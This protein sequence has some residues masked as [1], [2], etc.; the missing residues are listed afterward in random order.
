MLSEGAFHG[1]CEERTKQTNQRKRNMRAR[2]AIVLCLPP[3]GRRSIQRN[4]LLRRRTAIGSKPKRPRALRRP[5]FRDHNHPNM[6]PLR[7]VRSVS[8]RLAVLALM[9][10]PL[11]LTGCNLKSG[12]FIVTKPVHIR[13]F[14]AL[15]DGGQVT[16][17]VGDTTIAAGLP[18]EGLTSYQDTD[19]GN[20]E[21]KVTVGSGSTIVDQ[22]TLLLDDSKYTYLVYG[23]SAAPTAQLL[24]DSTQTPNGGEFALVVPNGAFGSGGLDFYVTTPGAPLDNMS[25]NLGNIPYSSTTSF[26]TFAAGAYQVRA[27]LPNSKQV[28]Y[29][30]GTVTFSERTVYYFFFYTRGS[31]TLVNAALLAEDTAGSGTLLNSKLAQFKVVHA[32]PGTDPINAQYDGNPAFAG[33]P[34]PNASSYA[35]LPAGTH[36]ITVETTTAPGALIASLQRSFDAAT[37]A[38]V[39]VTGLPGAQTAFALS[40][41]NLPGTAGTARIRFVNAAPNL[42]PVDVLVNFARKVASLS[43]NAGSSYI[44]FPEDTYTIDFTVAG[45]ATSLLTLQGVSL[46]AAR[47]YTLY[48]VGTSGQLTGLLTRDD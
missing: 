1:R 11:L 6:N 3:L 15:V 35:Q 37:D 44:E 10:L 32:A 46:T 21:I 47:T 34:Y 29:D 39:V 38:S 43:T 41:N 18:F 42:G 26:A 12:G 27:T 14:N 30:A 8:A 16:V 13:V 4:K 33:I 31:G 17:T 2:R 22:T 48:L 28:I 5:T 40:D 9:L 24:Q 23:T 25:P 20:Q 45:T 36:T 19:S 7:I